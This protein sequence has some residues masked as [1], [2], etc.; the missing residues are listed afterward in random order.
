MIT[1]V[2]PLVDVVSVV[3]PELSNLKS[4]NASASELAASLVTSLV[5]VLSIEIVFPA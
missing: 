5:S 2:V 4:P 1:F 3:A